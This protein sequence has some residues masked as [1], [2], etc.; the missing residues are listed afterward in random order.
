MAAGTVT[1]DRSADPEV[2]RAAG[3]IVWWRSGRRLR[4]ALVHRPKYGDWSLPKGKLQAGESWQ[5]AAL[6]EVREEIGCEARLMDF[7]GAVC[8]LVG[9]RPK[10]V[11]FWNMERGNGAF[12]PTP[13]VD[14]VEWL[15]RRDALAKLQHPA[16]R[17]LL[18]ESRWRPPLR[19]SAPE[20]RPG[21]SPERRRT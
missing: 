6:R 2:I 19:T 16:E 12:E 1:V 18:R 13:E 3:G 10:V 21:R 17:R 20:R 9:G 8:Y 7:A 4:L 14:R 11:L 5:A 15:S